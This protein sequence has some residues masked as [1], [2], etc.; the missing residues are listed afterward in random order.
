MLLKDCRFKNVW[1]NDQY[2][3]NYK[4]LMPLMPM[5]VI[6]ITLKLHF[7]TLIKKFMKQNIKNSIINV[8][9]FF[10]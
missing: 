6:I 10:K 3:L 5:D 1:Y 7:F 9:K 4:C 8:W 2:G